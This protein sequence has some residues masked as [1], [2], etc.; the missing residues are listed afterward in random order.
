[1]HV[2]PRKQASKRVRVCVV[3]MGVPLPPALRTVE[4][5]F[6]S[7]GFKFT[8]CSRLCTKN[9]GAVTLAELRS[10]FRRSSDSCSD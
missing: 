7:G 4:I 9:I 8:T 1:M 6:K 5:K 10:I 2:L 3:L